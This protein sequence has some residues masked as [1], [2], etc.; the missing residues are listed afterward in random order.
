MAPAAVYS[1]L[2]E[3]HWTQAGIGA[4]LADMG[5][6]PQEVAMTFSVMAAAMLQEACGGKTL[7]RQLAEKCTRR[8]AARS[9]QTVITRNTDAA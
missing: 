1:V 8:I 3:D 9:A 7:A 6:T 5:A 2:A 4:E